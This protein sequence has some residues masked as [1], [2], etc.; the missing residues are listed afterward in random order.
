[1]A[2][3][4]QQIENEAC[5]KKLVQEY[6]ELSL[7]RQ[8]DV[9]VLVNYCKKFAMYNSDVQSKEPESVSD[10]SYVHENSEL[11]EPSF[12]SQLYMSSDLWK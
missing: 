3:A 10:S 2:A 9:S 6:T 12:T 1:M 5:I 4:P 7:D 8:S 11:S